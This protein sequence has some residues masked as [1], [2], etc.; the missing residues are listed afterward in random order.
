MIRQVVLAYWIGW[1]E[2]LF[3]Q[4]A[5]K[6]SNISRAGAELFMCLFRRSLVRECGQVTT[7]LSCHS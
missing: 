5:S 4:R 3:L 2:R 7:G 1:R 6:A